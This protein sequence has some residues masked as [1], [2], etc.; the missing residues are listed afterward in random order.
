M[1]NTRELVGMALM[2]GAL[3]FASCT[4]GN[5]EGVACTNKDGC[6]A[7]FSC[8]MGKCTS[9]KGPDGGP[10]GG[11][12]GGS[13][14]T[15]GSGGTGGN[16]GTGGSGMPGPC[17]NLQCRQVMCAGGGTTSLSGKVYAPNG[18]LPLYNAVVYVPNA[19]VEAFK[20]GVSCDKCGGELSGSPVVQR[21]TDSTGSFRLEN[22]P[23]GDNVP[24]VIQI[25]RWRKQIV[26]PKVTQCTD[27]A[28][29]VEQ[30]RL[31]K[32]KAEGDIP[33][34]A[35]LTGKADPFQCLLRKIGIDDSEYT[36]N[37]GNGRVH[38]FAYK[39]GGSTFNGIPLA[40]ATPGQNDLMNS[41]PDLKK[42]DVVMLP[43]QGQ[44]YGQDKSTAQKQNL[45]E[46]ANAGGR[47]F[48]THF[49]YDWIKN[50]TQEWANTATWQRS[51]DRNR[52]F[53]YTLDVS[54]AKGKAFADW[55]KGQGASDGRQLSVIE[56]RT[57][58]Q[59]VNAGFAQRWLYD[60]SK[61]S[62]AHYTFN[63]PV[64]AKFADGGAP[65]QC[66]RVVFSD[67]HVSAAA[68]NTSIEDSSATF[69]SSCKNEP[70]NGQE[71]ALAFMLFDLSACVQR[72][73]VPPDIN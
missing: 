31:P 27:N 36:V 38:Y 7:G 46:F 32:S 64:A 40:S 72:D 6:P 66:G 25:G 8:F 34:M 55:L 69:P 16:A 70:L 37:T 68:L 28:L 50:N 48:A 59:S 58:A 73:D 39:V 3:V 13:S 15:G 22:V 14:G 23:A 62:I 53:P 9:A 56:S 57:N 33:Q 24:V 63:T 35:I 2:L 4:C 52:S 18:T 29:T 21:L 54:F 47:V 41:A 30:T 26:V 42:Y 1:K 51:D 11:S 60:D 5:A 20:P 67:F 49:S 10:L 19:P 45:I 65:E 44:E 71:K 43:C 61:P 12:G 17:V